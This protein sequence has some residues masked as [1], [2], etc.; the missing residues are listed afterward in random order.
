MLA[1]RVKWLTEHIKNYQMKLL[2]KFPQ[3]FMLGEEQMT[4]LYEDIAG[5]CKTV[6]L[7]E[8]QRQDYILTPG[9][10]VGLGRH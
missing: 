6:T 1:K 7:E 5:F 9:L 8:I 2:R 10:Y 3:Y 4:K